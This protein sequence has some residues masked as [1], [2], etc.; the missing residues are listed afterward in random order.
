MNG[1]KKWNKELVTFAVLKGT[2]DAGARDILR[3]AIGLAFS[4]WGA[5]IPLK[6]RRVKF[7]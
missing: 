5:E 3:K 2:E 7:S 4:T 6:F 1:V